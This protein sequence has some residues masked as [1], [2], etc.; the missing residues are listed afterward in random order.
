VTFRVPTSQQQE[1]AILRWLDLW[2]LHLRLSL[3]LTIVI[4]ASSRNP[5]TRCPTL[6]AST[7]SSNHSFNPS[8]KSSASSIDTSF[9][10]LSITSLSSPRVQLVPYARSASYEISLS[11][12]ERDLLD[13]AST[14]FSS[15]DISSKDFDFDDVFEPQRKLTKGVVEVSMS[16]RGKAERGYRD[17]SGFSFSHYGGAGSKAKSSGKAKPSVGVCGGGK[18]TARKH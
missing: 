10:T 9:S 15:L 7:S 11:S 18:A 3:A 12:T 6:S 13:Q 2:S 8:R 16:A 5:T 17:W 14:K 4:M 1:R